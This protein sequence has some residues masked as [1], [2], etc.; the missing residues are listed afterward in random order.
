MRNKI[1]AVLVLSSLSS[2]AFAATFTVV[3]KHKDAKLETLSKV[4]AK[5]TRDEGIFGGCGDLQSYKIAKKE[6][7]SNLNS[8]KQLH[9]RNG[10]L[11]PS[12]GETAARTKPTNS[13]SATRALLSNDSDMDW[14]D[15]DQKKIYEQSLT[16]VSDALYKATGALKDKSKE[17]YTSYHND[18]DGSWTILSVYD[19]KN[20]EVLYMQVGGCGT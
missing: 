14:L 12:N 5:A 2:G 19:T 15:E 20:Q 10:G 1:L 13:F 4:F 9:I 11:Q 17:L 7:E 3:N 6:T 16:D 8:M 18:E